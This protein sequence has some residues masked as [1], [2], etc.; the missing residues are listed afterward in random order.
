[1]FKRFMWLGVVAPL[2]VF[3]CETGDSTPAGDSTAG[4]NGSAAIKS[5][6]AGYMQLRLVAG[7]R[8]GTEP[9]A[10]NGKISDCAA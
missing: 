3:G 2:I 6:G 4:L 9:A 5:N 8:F 7:P 10:G 1:M